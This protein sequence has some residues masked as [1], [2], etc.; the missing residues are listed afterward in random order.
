MKVWRAGRMPALGAASQGQYVN[1]PQ[2][3]AT[4]GGHSAESLALPYAKVRINN[5]RSCVQRKTAL[6]IALL[7][8]K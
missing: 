3:P 5:V 7:Y 2:G 1:A 6:A 4:L 8:A